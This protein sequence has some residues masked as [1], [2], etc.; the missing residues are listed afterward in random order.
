[1]QIYIVS[2]M[3]FFFVPEENITRVEHLPGIIF[4]ASIEHAAQLSKQKAL[5]RW[6]V[7]EGW[8]SHQAMVQPVTQDFLDATNEARA[9]GILDLTTGE[10]PQ[11][12]EFETALD[13]DHIG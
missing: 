13:A 6:K 7:N 2:L 12:F 3:A 4:A 11:R 8:F 9:K 5:E 10:Q 1:M